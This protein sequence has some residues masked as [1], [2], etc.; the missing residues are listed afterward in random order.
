MISTRAFYLENEIK[1]KLYR[2]GDG[3]NEYIESRIGPNPLDAY[4]RGYQSQLER[5]MSGAAYFRCSYCGENGR[6]YSDIVTGRFKCFNC[7]FKEEYNRVS[8]D[9]QMKKRVMVWN[10]RA[11]REKRKIEEEWKH[12]FINPPIQPEELAMNKIEWTEEERAEI[13]RKLMNSI[14]PPDNEP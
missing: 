3:M 8:E 7:F 11:A 13:A 9:P 2:G 5:Q 10:L 14:D 4:M 12:N 6:G 1:K